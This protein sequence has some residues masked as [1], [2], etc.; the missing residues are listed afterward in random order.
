VLTAAPPAEAHVASMRA[1]SDG[2]VGGY[3]WRGVLAGRQRPPSDPLRWGHYLWLGY[4]MAWN[5]SALTLDPPLGFP[6]RKRPAEGFSD[7]VS[8]SASHTSLIRPRSFTG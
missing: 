6:L 8:H 3:Q 7:L 1:G 2:L 5:T 4:Y